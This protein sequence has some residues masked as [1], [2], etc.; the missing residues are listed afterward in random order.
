MR[1][2]PDREGDGKAQTR[3]TLEGTGTTEV[4][5]RTKGQPIPERKGQASSHPASSLLQTGSATK[6][7][8]LEQGVLQ[9]KGYVKTKTGFHRED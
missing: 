3:T 9:L 8:A 2:V 5:T 1:N 4:Q 7:V 6:A